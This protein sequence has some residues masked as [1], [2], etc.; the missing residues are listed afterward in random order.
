[1]PSGDDLTWIVGLDVAGQS[2]EGRYRGQAAPASEGGLEVPQTAEDLVVIDPERFT[3][4]NPAGYVE[5]RV[6]LT[7]QLL[8]LP[9]LRVDYYHHLR[10]AT[11]DPR[12]AQRLAVS[13]TLTL[14]SA[15]GWYSAPPLYYEAL[16]EIGNP[17]LSPSH[18]LHVSAGA[19]HQSEH[20]ELSGEAFYK[21]LDSRVVATPGGEPPHFVNDGRGR[22][23]GLELSGGYRADSGSRLSAT[24]TLSR[25]ERQDRNDAYRLFDYDQTHVLGLMGSLALGYG[26]SLGARFRVVTGN[27]STRVAGSVF[28]AGAGVYQ[29]VYGRPNGDRDPAFDQLDVRLDKRFTV[30]PGALLVYLDLQNVYAADNPEGYTY[31]YDYSVRQAATGTPFFP[32]LGLRGEL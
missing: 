31:S 23:L 8:L 16:P 2:L 20:M 26:F 6:H 28:D 29:P 4:F 25:S 1:V 22:V 9:S 32:N 14:K 15:V 27:P 30:G 13:E 10:D 19:E 5:A 18:A 7:E 12:L 24:Y 17:S 3:F 21:R 11:V